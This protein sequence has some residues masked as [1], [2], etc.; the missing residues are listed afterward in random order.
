MIDSTVT[1]LRREATRTFGGYTNLRSQL[2]LSDGVTND[3]SGTTYLDA[4]NQLGIRSIGNSWI[5]TK[6]NS[7]STIV[8]EDNKSKTTLTLNTGAN[9]NGGSAPADNT[10]SFSIINTHLGGIQ[11]RS[12]VKP[13]YDNTQK[14]NLI[15]NGTYTFDSAA[16][17][18]N[19]AGTNNTN[20]GLYFNWGYFPG[21]IFA[22][23]AHTGN[24]NYV[25]TSIYATHKIVSNSDIWYA[26]GSS[27]SHISLRNHTHPFSKGVTVKVHN[28]SSSSSSITQGGV[29]SNATIDVYARAILGGSGAWANAS[30]GTI[31]SISMNLT[32]TGPDN[33]IHERNVSIAPGNTYTAYNPYISV[34]VNSSVDQD[35]PSVNYGCGH[36][37]YVA[38][39]GAGSVTVQGTCGTPN[40]QTA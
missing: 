31:N 33:E 14:N 18:G 30:N 5:V 16:L 36:Y 29:G 39:E 38:D 3:S 37:A 2:Y 7:F 32:W 4:I 19:A 23:S 13:G 11:F 12:G 15:T 34:Y 21:R 26:S 40:F 6:G 28:S 9:W 20:G 1:V 10:N 22:N 17:T 24:I 8:G 25:D 35:S 27:N